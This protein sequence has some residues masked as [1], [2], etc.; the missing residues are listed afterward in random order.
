MSEPINLHMAK[1][2]Q[3]GEMC[4][5]EFD[6]AEDTGPEWFSDCC[7]SIMVDISDGCAWEPD[8]PEITGGK[9]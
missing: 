2:H 7:G 4:T 3:C 6:Y 8:Y 5:P 1:C 9:K